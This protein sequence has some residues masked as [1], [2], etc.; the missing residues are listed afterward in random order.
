MTERLLWT[1]D[2][3]REELECSRSTVR[4]LRADGLLIPIHLGRSI[5]YIP[6]EVRQFVAKLRCEASGQGDE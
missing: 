5:R 4:R 6:E 3:T 2:R 1:E